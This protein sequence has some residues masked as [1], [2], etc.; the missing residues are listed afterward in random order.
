[1]SGERRPTIPQFEP[2]NRVARRRLVFVAVA[3]PVMWVVALVVA[4]WIVE[5]SDAIETGLAITVGSFV[6][7]LLVLS[8]LRLGRRREER[9]YLD[10]R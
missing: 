1:M 2:L 8:L 10:R 3:G 6:L 4:A 9:R 7:A 5:T